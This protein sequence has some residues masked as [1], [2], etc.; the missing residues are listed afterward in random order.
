MPF[1]LLGL[2]AALVRAVNVLGYVEPTPVQTATVGVILKGSDVLALAQTGSGKT[3]AFCL[4]LL[5]GLQSPG[6]LP[7]TPIDAQQ[8]RRKSIR[9]LILVPTRELAVQVGDVIH[10][11]AQQLPVAVKTSVV[12]GGVSINPQMMGLRGGADIMVA[13]PGRLL[14]LIDH[15]ALGAQGLSHVNTLVLDEADRLLDLGFADELARILA[16]LPRKRQSLFFS[17]TFPQAVQA[18]ADALLHNAVRI[19]IACTPATLPVILQR[20]IEVDAHRRT[21]LLRHLV[22]QNVWKRVLVFVATKHAAEIVADKL[23]KADIDAEPFHGSLS[24]GKRSQVLA[25][26]KASRVRVVVATDLAARGLDIAELPVVVNY[27]LPRSSV[28]YIHRIGRTGR[29]GESGVAISFVTADSDA[30]FRLIE[31][32]Q[33]L[34]LQREQVPG[35]EPLE[36]F[37]TSTP[38]AAAPNT[39]GIKGHRPSKKDKLRAAAAQLNPSGQ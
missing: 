19:E 25:D 31:K 26:F 21:Q 23:R 11:L 12:F 6:G 8:H 33:A 35:F 13:T 38:E 14:D 29:A 30:Q 36:A 5:Q 24:Q 3:A 10:S 15:N 18:L 37:L 22:Q 16:L 32:R 1:S 27:D 2:N 34:T 17:A 7:S 4:P 39:G 20:V 28:D 9:A